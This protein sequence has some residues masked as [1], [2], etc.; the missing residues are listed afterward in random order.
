MKVALALSPMVVFLVLSCSN[1]DSSSNANGGTAGSAG[2]SATGGAGGGSGSAGTG[3]RGTGGTGGRSDDAALG[4]ASGD[5]S[6]SVTQPPF[7]AAPGKSW[8]LTFAEE[9][10]GTDFDH[11]KLSPC[12]DWN[13]G[14]CTS[15]FNNGYEHY[16]PSQVRV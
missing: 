6:S 3:G 15:S 1:D 16:L 12:F 9:F 8:T 4:D 11:N 2:E 13:T 7:A 10:D 5:G 14:D